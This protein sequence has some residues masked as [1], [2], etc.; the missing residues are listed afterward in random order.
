[1]ATTKTRKTKPAHP[2][3]ATR[4]A[5]WLC[6]DPKGV[7]L[8]GGRAP[9]RIKDASGERAYCVGIAPTAEIEALLLQPDGTAVYCTLDEESA[10]ANPDLLGIDKLLRRAFAA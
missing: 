7:I 10:E 3:A 8:A 6:D 4:T 5:K 9:C 1:M 2:A